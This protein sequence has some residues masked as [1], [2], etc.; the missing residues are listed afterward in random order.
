MYMFISRKRQ[1]KSSVREVGQ[2]PNGLARGKGCLVTM[3]VCEISRTHIH[4]NKDIRRI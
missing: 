1:V 4:V 3:E 2:V